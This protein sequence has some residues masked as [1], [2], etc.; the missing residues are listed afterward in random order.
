MTF[1]PEG[2]NRGNNWSLFEPE[3][4][5]KERKKLGHQ[6]RKS[7]PRVSQGTWAQQYKREHIIDLIKSQESY[8]RPTLI[9][10]RY[11]RMMASPSAFL[12]GSA[13][14]MASDLSQT[15]NSQIKV[16]CCGD[17]HLANFGVFATPER[18]IC[19]D[20]ND[21]DET[22][23]G[24][25]E[26]DIKRLAA[27]FAVV[28]QDKKHSD[29]NLKKCLM[30]LAKTYRESMEMFADM[31]TIEIWYYRVSVGDLIGRFTSPEKQS[32]AWQQ[33]EKLV[34]K[35]THKGAFEKLTTQVD[36][37]RLIKDMPP[38]IEH[39]DAINRD[40]IKHL[41]DAYF[42]TMAPY[43]QQLLS[44]YRFV[45]AALKVVGVGSVGTNAGLVL[46]QG[47]ADGDDPIFLQLK[48]ATNS[49]LEPYFPSRPFLHQ[50]ER[51]VIGQTLIQAAPDAF[52][53]WSSGPGGVQYYVRQFMDA[54][55]AVPI[56][57]LKEEGLHHYAQ[58]CAIT[59]ARAHARSGDAA[60]LHGYLGKSESFDEA[61]TNFALNYLKQNEIDYQI[62]L[63][64]I[65]DGRLPIP[66]R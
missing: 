51:V 57:E 58:S 13:I 14:I 55:I 17:C 2:K 10:L 48:Q 61:I 27:S 39:P 44:R 35:R 64:A 5:A 34:K 47:Q 18:N 66:D 6:L 25:W 30:E 62:F 43:K 28:A 4:P 3:L 9:P 11:Q 63:N 7:C 37:K 56:D 53:G 15:A 45:D 42:E 22:Y 49:V 19:F 65:K 20:L 21:F 59:L 26:W 16:Q 23:P 54:K 32:Q 24:P 33:L 41:L 1:F 12:R 40:L 29:N 46:L 36:G 8:R 52:L 50:G 38:V 31:K 60:L